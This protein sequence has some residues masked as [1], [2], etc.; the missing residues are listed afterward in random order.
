MLPRLHFILTLLVGYRKKHLAVFVMSIAIVFLLSSVVFISSSLHES[1]F[2]TLAQ[3]ADIT[4]QKQKGGRLEDVPQAWLDQFL[5]IKGVTEAQGRVYG[6]HFYEPKEHYFFIVG[7]DFY[8]KQIVQSLQTLVDTLDV[9]EFLSK[10]Q[11]IIG[12]GVKAF[13]D[14]LHYFKYYT[15]RPPDRSKQK[16]YIYNHFKHESDILTN[17]MVIMD[18]SLARKILGIQEGYFSD[19]ILKVP[20]KKEREMVYEKL[21]IS[22][23]DTRI[24]TK[25]DIAKHYKKLFNYKGGVFMVLYIFAIVTFLLLLYQRYSMVESLDLKEIVILRSTGWSIEQIIS[26]KLVENFIVVFS[27]YLMGIVLAYIYVFFLDAPLLRDIFL[28]SA[29]LS[30]HPEFIPYIKSLDLLILFGIFVLPFLLVVVVPVWK[31]C[32]KDMSEMIR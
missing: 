15:F 12:A 29:N 2:T 11:M 16:V 24:I 4:V 30:I 22:H 14:D 27:A 32:V 13:L 19:I 6:M 9:E 3:Q 28:G 25:K 1:T 18:I 20:N 17:D 21:I 26:F 10:K 5:N 31:L 8:D 23:F 7:V